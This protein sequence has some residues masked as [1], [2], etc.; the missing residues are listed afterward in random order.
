[1]SERQ[2]DQHAVLR[3]E[4]SERYVIKRGYAPRESVAHMRCFVEHL[5]ECPERVLAALL[6]ECSSSTGS[7]MKS[8]AAMRSYADATYF[9]PYPA[10]RAADLFDMFQPA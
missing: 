5:K 10:T 3:D 7:V 1:L 4:E 2:R 8:A 6:R 9:I